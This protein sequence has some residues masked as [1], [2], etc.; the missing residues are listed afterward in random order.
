MKIE[1]NKKQAFLIE[2]ALD[3]LSRMTCG[4]LK[5]GVQGIEIY[6]KRCFELGWQDRA[7]VDKLWKKIKD[8]LFPQLNCNASYGVGMEE[9]GDA[10][11]AYEMVKKLQNFRIRDLP[12]NKRGVLGH[13]PLH[14]SKK[15]LIKMEDSDEN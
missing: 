15:P 1:C 14:Y 13:E 8:I 4:Q 6:R 9:I 5:A 10:Q 2:V 12:K 11:I 3:T 7:Q